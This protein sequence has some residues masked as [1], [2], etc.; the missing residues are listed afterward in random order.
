MQLKS[1]VALRITGVFLLAMTS[2]SHPHHSHGNYEAGYVDIEGVVTEVHLINPHSWI[3]LQVE[4]ANIQTEVWALEAASRGQLER[5]GIVDDVLNPG[6]R[7]KV[8]CHPLR[9]RSRGCLLGFVKT[10]D[11]S[12]TDWDG[13]N[14]PHPADF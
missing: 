5:I 3:Y 2:V 8:R 11:G 6:D 9:D 13:T 14:L 12:I 1:T 7:I 4:G 10:E